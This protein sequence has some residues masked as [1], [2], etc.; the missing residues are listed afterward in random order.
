[1]L[2]FVKSNAI[3]LIALVFAMTGTGLAA[4]HYV[5]TSTKQIKPSVLKKLHGARGS[6]GATGH[7][8]SQGVQG[9]VGRQGLPG[10]Q[11]P[12]G[13]FPSSLPAGKTLTGTWEVDGNNPTKSSTTTLSAAI[14]FQFPLASPPQWAYESAGEH[15]KECPG[16]S[17]EPNATAGWMCVYEAESG[18][19]QGVFLAT[20]SRFGS[21]IE[22][23]S[24]E[25][26][27]LFYIYG[28]WAVTG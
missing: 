15:S 5:I 12:E 10:A 6:R 23:E 25:T 19:V 16:S 7:T 1:M 18:S 9:P 2:R 28:T 24:E 21:F 20:P 17:A 8:G 14:S 11:G 3:A 13:P 27:G 26:E 22:A 4:S